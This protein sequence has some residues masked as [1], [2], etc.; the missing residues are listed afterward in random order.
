MN[1][2]AWPWL[3]STEKEMG[4]MSP[5]GDLHMDIRNDSYEGYD[6]LSP[7][8]HIHEGTAPESGSEGMRN[9]VQPTFSEMQDDE[10]SALKDMVKA[11]RDYL[12][13]DMTVA[14]SGALGQKLSKAFADK[15]LNIINLVKNSRDKLKVS[16]AHGESVSPMFYRFSSKLNCFI[17]DLTN[18]DVNEIDISIDNFSKQL[19][20]DSLGVIVTSRDNSIE[21]IIDGHN[22]KLLS[23]HSG[24]F[25]KYLVKNNSLS[26]VAVA[27]YYNDKAEEAA[28]FLCDIADST[29]KKI[30]GLQVYSRLKKECGLLF[31]YN[32]PTDAMFHMGSVSYPIDII[33]IDPNDTVKKISKNIE[34]GSLEVFSCSGVTNVLEISGG[35]S[36]LLNIKVGGKI[37]ITKGDHYSK[38]ISKTGALLEDLNAKR[39]AFKMSKKGNSMVHLSGKSTVVRVKDNLAPD[40]VGIIRKFAATNIVEKNIIAIDADTF[41]SA[42]GSIRLYSSRKAEEEERVS[43][44][45][46]RESFYADENTYIDVPPATFFR[47]GSYKE[48]NKKYS[49]IN[50]KSSLK[51][52]SDDH[53][54]I[55]KKLSEQDFTDIILVSRGSL[56]AQLFDIFLE[57]SIYKTFGEKVSIDSKFMRVPANYGSEGV[58]TAASERHGDLELFSNFL[59]KEGGMPVSENVKERAREALKY[60]ARSKELCEDIKNNFSKNI[61]AYQGID[62]NTEAVKGSRGKYNESCKRNSR[63]TKRMLLNVKSSIQILNQ[64]KDIATTGEVI[65]AIAEAAKVSSESISAVF[66]LLNV[67]DSDDFVSRLSEET[68]KAKSSLEDTVLSLD[69]AKDYV[70][71]DILGILVITE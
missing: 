17:S 32:R 66:G 18:L 4:S 69:R 48:L 27:R 9:I 58:Y 49:Y 10:L 46:Y 37:Y 24:L 26:T 15:N 71:S 22:L 60:I 2:Q 65:S 44:G 54:K 51:P 7:V 63:I 35:L 47:K 5:S 1:K 61:E 13:E 29:E 14:T 68:E 25:N 59:V 11:L 43:S 53:K 31:P 45:I 55:L 64:I 36:D 70:N 6:M 20:F 21:H 50:N 33:F 57:D 41:L 23:K 40:A 56:D 42:M 62:G 19:T 39:V 8:K 34:P 28:S 30:D 67:I 16:R 3:G 52:F 12:E 38:A